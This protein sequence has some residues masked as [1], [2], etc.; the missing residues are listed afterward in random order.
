MSFT[1]AVVVLACLAAGASS[2]ASNA[3]GGA[4]SRPGTVRHTLSLSDGVGVTLD[5][6]MVE[7]VM[8]SYLFVRDPWPK[9]ELLPVYAPIEASS[10]SESLRLS[11][12]EGL[13]MLSVEVTGRTMTVGGK[14]IVAASRIRL[15]VNS[16][17]RPTPPLPKSPLR[18]LSWR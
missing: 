16:N 18:A 15:Y 8:G 6:V 1:R 2:C 10:S 5:A 4:E 9:S 14:R 11:L 7:R 17:G 3:A 13:R 12:P